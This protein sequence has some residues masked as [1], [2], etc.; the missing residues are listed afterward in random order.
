MVGVVR[1]TSVSGRRAVWFAE[2]SE[3]LPNLINAF[4]VSL[5]NELLSDLTDLMFN[6]VQRTFLCFATYAV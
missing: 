2:D 5:Q 4:A 1:C 6:I 3:Q